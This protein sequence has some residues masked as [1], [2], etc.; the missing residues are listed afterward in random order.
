MCSS[1][2][3]MNL[4]A[5]R[6]DTGA[7]CAA[8]LIEETILGCGAATRITPARRAVSTDWVD[9]SDP[10]RAEHAR[11]SRRSSKSPESGTCSACASEA[12][13]RC[14]LSPDRSSQNAPTRDQATSL[15]P[16][17]RRRLGVSMRFNHGSASLPV[18]SVPT[19]EAS[20]GRLPRGRG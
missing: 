19:C 2:R 17:R 13:F 3:S 8:C 7:P 4:A 16:P 10:S 15:R 11:R 12:A 5:H 20:L 14:S 9:A 6:R 1:N 18:S